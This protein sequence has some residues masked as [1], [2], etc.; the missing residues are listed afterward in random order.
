MCSIAPSWNVG[1]DR[2]PTLWTASAARSTYGMQAAA[3]LDVKELGGEFSAVS[4]FSSL[5]SAILMTI[6]DAAVVR[7]RR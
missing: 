2:T 6:R 3:I 1:F 4:F 5:C 7:L